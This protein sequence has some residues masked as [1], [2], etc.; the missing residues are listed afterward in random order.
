MSK[1]LIAN[2]KANKSA[3]GVKLWFE[4]FETTLV[5]LLAGQKLTQR[6]VVAGSFPLLSLVRDRLDQLNLKLTTQIELGAGFELGIQ[7]I[8]QYSAG[9]YTGAVSGQ[10]IAWLKPSLVLLGHS[11]RRKYFQE[12]TQMVAA[13]CDQALDLPIQAVVCLD[14]SQISAQAQALGSNLLDKVIV[15]YEPVEAIGSGIHPG[16][17]TVKTVIQEIKTAF[18]QA[19]PILYGGSVD[20]STIGQYLLVSDGVIVGT[21]ALDGA[22]FARVVAASQGLAIN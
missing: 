22:Q 15:A 10:N 7:D 20:E 4:D 2:W 3:A 11:E 19:I 1:L 13:K 17:E 9:S 6:I 12:T 8:S 18:S 16:V 14:R 21:A 5:K